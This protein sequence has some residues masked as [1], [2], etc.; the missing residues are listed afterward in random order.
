MNGADALV[1]PPTIQPGQSAV[2]YTAGPVSGSA[3]AATS[4]TIRPWQFGAVCQL[5]LAIHAEQ[6]LD[7][8]DHAVSLQ[9]RAFDVA[10]TFAITGRLFYGQ[11]MRSDNGPAVRQRTF[12][13]EARRAQIIDCA[14]E[15][16]AEFGY[17]QTSFARIAERAGVSKSVISYHFS[18]KDELLQ[19]VVEYVYAKGARYMTPLIQ[20]QRDKS[21]PATLA[22]V[23]R[24]NLEFIRDHHKDIAAVG[25]IASGVRTE[26]GGRRFAGGSGGIE[27][28]IKLLQEI[29]ARGQAE[30]DFTDFDT[31]TMAWTI[32][33][34][35]DGVPR[36][37]ALDPEFEF[38]TCI[39]ELIGQID[40]ATRRAR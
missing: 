20:A 30:G 40:R 2:S 31:R 6:P 17:A 32:R 13:E 18:S 7:A 5:G 1:P 38:D 15:V 8:P 21:A 22:A 12:T 10:F 37:Q 19:Q 23:L 35:I 36:Q 16:L 28:S 26:H 29:L 27:Q 11:N 39:T 34:L 25:E 24:T 9:P 14:I 3:S 33:H 4:A